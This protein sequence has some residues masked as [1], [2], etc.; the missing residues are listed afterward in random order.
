VLADARA[1]AARTDTDF[2]AAIDDLN[3]RY[4]AGLKLVVNP[5]PKADDAQTKDPAPLD[6][7]LDLLTVKRNAGLSTY[8]ALVTSGQRR[9]DYSFGDTLMMTWLYVEPKTDQ[10][11]WSRVQTHA[12]SLKKNAPLSNGV[13][14]SLA[15]DTA[16]KYKLQSN[17]A[18]AIGVGLGVIYTKLSEPEYDAVTNPAN[19]DEKLVSQ[20]DTDTLA[21]QLALFADWRLL[22]L[23]S[24]KAEQWVLRPSLQVGTNVSTTPG[25][26]VGLGVDV[27]RYFRFGWGH[28]WQQSKRLSPT[29]V[30][31]QTVIGSASDIKTEDFFARGQYFSFSFALDSLPLFKRSDSGSGSEASPNQNVAAAAEGGDAAAAE[32][33]RTSGQ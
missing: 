14:G 15:D 10:L 6:A 17:K 3:T 29:Q 5:P 4:N 30:A 12:F 23:F 32:K 2:P 28:T 20:V 9:H 1:L 24:R 11:P 25:F 8:H 7:A 26:F 18:A 22:S 27:F 33:K 31:D 19:K 13:T 21:G 16:L